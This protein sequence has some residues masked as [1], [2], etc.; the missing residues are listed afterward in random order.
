[1]TVHRYTGPRRKAT[2]K[3][4][5]PTCG[6]RATRSATFEGTVNPF[7]KNADGT[8]KTWEQVAAD[9]QAKAD[10]WDPPAEVFEHD[11]CQAE[12]LAPPVA[13]PAPVSD[14]RKRHTATVLDAMDQVGWFVQQHGLPLSKVE[15]SSFQGEITVQVVFVPTSD[16]IAWA[17]AFG[18]DTVAVDDGGHGTGV[19]LRHRADGLTWK[20]DAWVSR[21]AVGDRLGDTPIAWRRDQRTGRRTKYGT[22]RVDDLADGLARMG[23]AVTTTAPA[24][25]A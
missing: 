14:E 1:M 3:G 19:R 11:K 9:V 23:I 12:R 15:V 13:A 21:P 4:T 17:R 8:V 20:V 18:L 16:V 5:C 22:V 7:N 6:K 25:T 24:V 2:R 10:A